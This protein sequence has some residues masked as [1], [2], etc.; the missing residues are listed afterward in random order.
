M[1]RF[2]ALL[3]CLFLIHVARSQETLPTPP[4]EENNPTFEYRKIVGLNMTPLL[5]QLI[6]FNRSNPREAGPYLVH[7][8]KYGLSGKNAFRFSMGIH[9]V[10]DDQDELADPQFNIAF[11]WEKRR[12]ISKRWSYTRGFDFMFLAGDLNVP[13]VANTEESAAIAFG[14]VWGIEFAIDR[15]I[16]IGTEAALALGWSPDSEGFLF[17]IIPPLGIFLHHYF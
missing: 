8:K 12:S 13:G 4:P 7:F 5:T 16:T 3:T 2:A 9:L 10:P 15:R 11:G 14:P 17:D 1:K 6:P